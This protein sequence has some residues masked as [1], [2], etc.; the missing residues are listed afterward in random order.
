MV[1]TI[2]VSPAEETDE[3]P[4][5]TS[6]ESIEEQKSNSP[7]EKSDTQSEEKKSKTKQYILFALVIFNTITC[8]ALIITLPIVLT[9]SSSTDEESLSTVIP[10]YT[11]P[12]PENAVLV[13]HSERYSERSDR[14]S[15]PIPFVLDFDGKI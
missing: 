5:G 11:T 10:D 15:N 13:L 14:K 12:I 4:L 2:K 7:S 6:N 3:S 1:Q 8:I 9:D